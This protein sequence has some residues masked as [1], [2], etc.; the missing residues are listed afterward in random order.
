MTEATTERQ[1]AG[2][3]RR[4]RRWLGP[5]LSLTLTLVGLALLLGLAGM[6]LTGRSLPLPVWAVA[7]IED[8]LNDTLAGSHLPPGRRWRWTRS[9]LGLDRDL[10]PRLRLRDLQLIDAQGGAVLALPELAIALDGAALL[11]GQM[12]PASVRLLGAHLQARRD[13]EGRLDLSIGGLSG[14][15]QAQRLADVL[16]ALDRMFSTPALADLRLVEADALTLTL[17]DDRAGRTWQLG[18]GRLV[19]E[20]GPRGWP[21]IW[22]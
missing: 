22:G 12:H 5:V 16:D 14:A 15:P 20:N 13:A 7:E 11:R 4:G 21:P 10:T 8:R 6:A 9:T 1:G 3:P 18:D 19:L 17:T 2:P